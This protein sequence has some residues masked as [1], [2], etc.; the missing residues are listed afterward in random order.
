MSNKLHELLAVKGNLASQANA[1]ITNLVSLFEK[2]RHIF[3]ESRVIF[4][5]NQEGAK[6]VEESRS[7]LTATVP[8]VLNGAAPSIAKSMD[9]EF[10]IAVTNC[11][12]VADVVF[13]DGTPLMENVPATALLELEKELGVLQKLITVVPVFDSAKGFQP[14]KSR[15]NVWVARENTKTRTKKSKRFV[16]AYDATKEHPAQIK[17]VDEDIPTGTIRELEWTGLVP[18]VQRAAMLSR[19]DALIRA[20][21][22]ARSRANER[23]IDSTRKV[24]KVVLDYVLGTGA[25]T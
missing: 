1:E 12:A 13:E 19:C 15:E 10:Q 24:G 21:R 22:A 17:E 20:V 14:D 9:A 3:S 11:D 7:E 18:P 23:V 4:A 8:G 16:V 25:Q 5:P 2:Q 6:E